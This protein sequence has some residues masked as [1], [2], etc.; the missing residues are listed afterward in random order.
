MAD[1]VSSYAS[2]H[3]WEDWAETWAHYLHMV[4]TL[5]TA[6]QYRLALATPGPTP[7]AEPLS[8]A[9][10]AFDDFDSLIGAWS[11]LTLALNGL[12]RSMG[13]SDMYPFVLPDPVHDKL[14]F[15]HR[16]VREGLTGAESPLVVGG[17]PESAQRDRASGSAHTGA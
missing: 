17:S 9:R 16:T 12:S 13:L 11:G 1:H 14:R 10:V 7:D 6:S 5:E 3:P 8:L 2:M 4:D 15:V